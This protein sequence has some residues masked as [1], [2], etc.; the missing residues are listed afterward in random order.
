MGSQTIRRWFGHLSRERNTCF[1]RLNVWVFLVVF[2]N[3]FELR[4]VQVFA[5]NTRQLALGEAHHGQVNR[6]T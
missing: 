3:C 5:E 2:V 6:M 4:G 1:P